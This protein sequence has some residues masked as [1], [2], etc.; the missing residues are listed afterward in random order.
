[1]ANYDAQIN[2]LVGGINKIND[3]EDRLSRIQDTIEEI[4][5]MGAEG[6]FGRNTDLGVYNRA[7]R[8]IN[9]TADAVRR[10][11]AQQQ[12]ANTAVR[13]QL[14][15]YSRLNREQNLFRRRSAAFTE[16][17]RG[18][19]E[20]NT[21]VIELTTQ[22]RSA[23]K[24]FSALFA[25]AD[26]QGIKVLNTEISALLE[27]LR[28]INRV[29]AGTK[30]TGVNT[31]QLQAQADGWAQQI[32]AL[33]QRA[34]LLNENEEILARLTIAERNLIQ[35]RNE[36]MTFRSDANVRLGKQELAN[37]IALVKAEEN[38]ASIRRRDAIEYEKQLNKQSSQ[39]KSIFQLASKT[40]KAAGSATLDAVTFGNGSQVAKGARN[41]AIRGGLGLGALGLG[42]AYA[43][44]QEAIGNID[45][46]VLQSPATQA[47]TAIGGAIN[48]ALGGIPEIISNVLSA[49]GDIPGALGLA[50]VAALAFAPAMKTAGEAVYLAGKKFGE[51]KFGENIKLTLER[52][53]N[54]FESVI[55]KASEMNMVLDT[56]K[57][58]LDAVG[59]AVQSLPGLPA[60]GET[61]FKGEIRQVAD[62]G[63]L[64]AIEEA[65]ARNEAFPGGITTT[66]IGGGARAL[67]N[68]EFLADSAGKIAAR[69]QEAADA[70]LFLAERLGAGSAEA[71]SF[72]N[73]LELSAQ[74]AKKIAEYLEQAKNLRISPKET[75]TQ[76]FIR[77]N[78]DRGRLLNEN[79]ASA[80]IARERSAAILGSQYSLQQVPVRGELL[81][82]G[83][84]ETRQPDY[85]QMLN[86][87]ATI[88]QYVADILETMSKQ[89]GVAATLEQ[90]ER[91]TLGNVSEGIAARR[92]ALGVMQSEVVTQKQIN[93]ENERSIQIIRERNRELRQRPISA[94]TPRE[95]GI[96]ATDTGITVTAENIL[97]PATLAAERK[98]RIA[99]GRK[100]QES[101]SRARSEGLIG[102]AFPLL[103][104]QGLGASVGG[105]LGGAVG[106][107]AGGGLGF[108]LSLV[109]TA[110]GTALDTA[111]QS[112]KELGAALQKPVENFDKFVDSSF[113][114]SRALE[115][116]IKKT[117]EYGD[118]ASASAMIQEEAIRKFG[119]NG[120][121]NLAYLESES[122]KLNRAWA[123]LGQS[124]QAL[125]AGPLGSLLRTIAK[126]IEKNVAI[127]RAQNVASELNTT[128]QK[129]FRQELVNAIPDRRGGLPGNI[130]TAISLFG[131]LEPEQLKKITEKWEP[132]LLK[133][134]IKI[135]K[136]QIDES[137]LDA[138]QKRLEGI[139]IAKNVTDQIRSAA[140]EQQDLDKQRADL[141]RSYEEDIANVKKQVE[142]E[143]AKRRFATI[144]KENQLL[145]VQGEIRLKQLQIANQAA[146]ASAG[147]GQ[148]TEAEQA[149]KEVAR[150]IAQF[151]EQQLTAEESAAKIKRNAALEAQKIDADA[152]QLKANIEKEISRLNIET[153]RKVA[154]INDQVKRKNEELDTRRF[155]IERSIAALKL[156]LFQDELALVVENTQLDRESRDRAYRFYI[157]I[158]EERLKIEKLSAPAPLRGVGA[159]GGGGVSV[160]GL[161]KATSEY[162]S[163]VANYVAA[164]L[165]LNELDVVKNAQEFSLG[166]L[167][168]ADKTDAALAA[169]Q[170]RE[171][172]AEAERLRYMELVNSGLTDTV[173]QKVIELE[174]TKQVAL[175]VYDAAIA[176]LDSKIQAGEV[177]A[178]IDAQ[179]KK[180]LEQIKILKDRKDAIAGKF[181]SF[182]TKTGEGTGAI[183]GA[184]K[185]KPGEKINAFIA[186]AEA[187]LNDLE[188]VA[189][190]I[191]QGIGDAVGNS[192]ATGITGLI[193]GTTTAK[194]IFANFLKDVGQ[195][196]IQEAT[197]MIAI[198]VALAIARQFAGLAGSSSTTSSTGPNPGGI[199]STGNV[200]APNI[201]GVDTGAAAN[202]AASGAY[203]SSGLAH[204]ANGGMF[205]NSIVASPTLFKFADGGSVRTGL[206]GEAGPEAIMP[207]QR[208]PDGKLGVS[209]KL[210]GAVARY[211]RPQRGGAAG[212]ATVGSGTGDASA[213][214]PHEPIDVRYSVE[215]INNVDYVT[216]D[217]FQAGMQQAAAQGAQRGEQRALRSLQQSTAVRSRVGMR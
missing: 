175:A 160:A 126:P 195:I 107:F 47:A 193:E 75:P 90:I 52:Q 9:A 23:Q 115:N 166:I 51:S 145:D 2:I 76:R 117:I 49:L 120:V 39:I 55:N 7:L 123:E 147:T 137:T 104:G 181:G 36:D 217:Q 50:S 103:F 64:R 28:E 132:I 133:G 161:N 100:R 174:V 139:D 163:A 105:G 110:L 11:T 214:T 94:M 1:M 199:P 113:F 20:T 200:T 149:A 88:R 37:S 172:D 148:R 182:D 18:I 83:R 71:S 43:A 26:V 109:G 186:D 138:L 206:M 204:F 68:A 198:Y 48:N 162:K 31:G 21:R 53:T 136:K 19:R 116:Q 14:L 30:N 32:A 112:A 127:S 82:G 63:T 79:Q 210:D 67:K 95:R 24:A 146:I 192:L 85:R 99:R 171:A 108:G 124:M 128:Q 34:S 89:Q 188:S 97:D 213:V 135:D 102:G 66:F 70:T 134:K 33:R 142:D 157:L 8:E 54:L 207:L 46:G 169:I 40:L 42:G 111:V 125:I 98:R 65:K 3:L 180:Y 179:N 190:N 130:K 5:T 77:E 29:A 178:E 80:Q 118:A 78:V 114:S 196:L 6:I 183:G 212:A 187:K 69:S 211:G 216:A 72:A 158:K 189:I 144:E 96:I 121:K 61:S 191:S 58:G 165:R 184:A 12:E 15:L 168:F 215:R 4:N 173:A 170:T 59:R 91:R 159:V 140:R 35:L 87:Q 74:E 153:A 57:S 17:S 194:D 73:Q 208:G 119:V 27:E 38:L 164:E 203:F 155:S 150:I 202:I 86:N 122:D 154:E 92:T 16:E 22:L 151:S 152:T 176:Q 197:K 209:A 131:S 177:T 56:S 13:D 129:Q 84:T 156:R 205:S 60:A 185:T 62:R 25:D 141:V 167:S 81:P 143:I 41:A 101:I 10:Q 45:L 106:G 93:D 201:N 44:T